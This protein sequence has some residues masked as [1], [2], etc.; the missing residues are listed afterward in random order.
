MTLAA[1]VVFGSV[2]DTDIQ[3]LFPGLCGAGGG[4]LR[5]PV[6]LDDVVTALVVGVD[7]ICNQFRGRLT[8]KQRLNQRLLNRNGAVGRRRIT[9]GFEVVCF[10]NR[11]T[12]HFGGFVGVRTQIDAGSWPS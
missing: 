8:S 2:D 11:P 1:S 12:S 10:R 3:R 7:E 4:P 5:F 6:V 9:P